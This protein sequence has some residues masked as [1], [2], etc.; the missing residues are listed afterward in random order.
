MLFRSAKLFGSTSDDVLE[1]D[2]L[3]RWTIDPSKHLQ[4]DLHHLAIL[5]QRVNETSKSEF[6]E[7]SMLAITHE[8]INSLVMITEKNME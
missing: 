3:R 5:V 6:P 2:K 7:L 8:A 1:A 4:F